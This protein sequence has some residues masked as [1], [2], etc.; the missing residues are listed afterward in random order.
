M[1]CVSFG[2]SSQC[3]SSWDWKEAP[4]Q[5]MN[6]SSSRNSLLSAVVC[7]LFRLV[8]VGPKNPHILIVG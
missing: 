8:A 4:E 1:M 3:P 2:L 5:A 6:L 7:C